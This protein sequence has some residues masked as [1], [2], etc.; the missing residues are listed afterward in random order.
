MQP[1]SPFQ[2]IALCLTLDPADRGKSVPPAPDI[3][4]PGISGAEK[5]PEEGVPEWPGSRSATHEKV[6]AI[7]RNPPFSWEELVWTASSHLVMPALFTALRRHHLLWLLPEE[8]TAHLENVW[9]LNHYRN[10]RIIGQ[11]REIAETLSAAG[12]RP[13]FLKGAAGVISSLYPETADRIM[14]DIDIL[15]PSG[16]VD[17]AARA[18]LA[19]GYG[20]ADKAAAPDPEHHHHYP[21][22]IREGEVAGIE[23]HHRVTHRTYSRILTEQDLFGECRPVFDG[24]A[25]IPSV[26]HQIL[27]H[28][29]HDQ[30]VHWQLQNRTQ[31]LRGLYDLYLLS[32]YVPLSGLAPFSRRL[33]SR[34][35]AY[36]AVAALTFGDP[37]SLQLPRGWYAR[38][39]LYTWKLMQREEPF[40]RFLHRAL[41][42]INRLGYLTRFVISAAYR[43]DR[44][45]FL[46]RRMIG[47]AKRKGHSA[48]GKAQRA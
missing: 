31:Q 23:L 18:I 43:Q 48:K 30:L 41:I 6:V 1:I 2:F 39:Y 42:K 44:R 10:L 47:G 9:S 16:E 3:I 21:M 5:D 38:C 20:Y 7:L 37:A 11:A 33:R 28:F 32:Q 45:Y 17:R 26:R 29:I 40:C 36:A 15:V 25:A 22:M 34:F 35:S 8:L 27:H 14:I 12:I 24:L 19:S 13:L 46:V 4:S